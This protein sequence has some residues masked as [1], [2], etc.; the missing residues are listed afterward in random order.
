[1]EHFVNIHIDEQ[2]VGHKNID[3][4][5]YNKCLDS[6]IEKENDYWIC[7]KCEYEYEF[8]NKTIDLDIFNLFKGVYF[9]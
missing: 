9:D 4:P 6:N 1:M 8:T 5:H 2:I 3:C 7:N